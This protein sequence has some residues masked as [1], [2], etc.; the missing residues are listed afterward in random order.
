MRKGILKEYFD[1]LLITTP[2]GN[3]AL[4]K[5]SEEAIKQQKEQFLGKTFSFILLPS[6]KAVCLYV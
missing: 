2:N 3:F 5:G 4:C 1:E 6:N